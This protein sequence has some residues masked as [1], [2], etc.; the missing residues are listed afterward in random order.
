MNA[1]PR[2]AIGHIPFPHRTVAE[3]D[4]DRRGCA[5]IP[6]HGAEASPDRT[7]LTIDYPQASRPETGPDIAL[8]CPDCFAGAAT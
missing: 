7:H 2:P 8:F 4:S 5:Q 6:E 1:G 3:V